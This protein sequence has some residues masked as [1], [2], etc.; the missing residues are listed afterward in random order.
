MGGAAGR[1]GVEEMPSPY[2]AQQP[3]GGYMMMPGAG[4]GGFPVGGPGM[5]YAGGPGGFMPGM[6]QMPPPRG[7]GTFPMYPMMA[8]Q[9]PGALGG[10]RRYQG[11]IKSFNAKQGFGFIECPEAHAIYGR[12]VFLH[13][14]QIGDLKVGTEVTYGVE[15]NKQGM[16]QARDIAT[17]DG[18]APGPSPQSVAKGDGGGGGGGGGRGGKGGGGGAGGGG[19]GG[20]GKRRGGKGGDMENSGTAPMAPAAP[21]APLPHVEPEPEFAG[22]A[23]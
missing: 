10:A 7:Q 11:R 23:R 17:L 19:R 5:P 20:G 18:L 6:P 16:P 8:Q 15:M 1:R 14:A 22:G 4:Y 21:T 9:G 12:D 13:K 2:A 3:F